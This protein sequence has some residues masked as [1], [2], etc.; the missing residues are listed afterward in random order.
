MAG[1]GRSPGLDA[2][3]FDEEG[4]THGLY[5]SARQAIVGGPV[6]GVLAGPPNNAARV[7]PSC[8]PRP[9][10]SNRRTARKSPL[11]HH[12]DIAEFLTSRRAKITPEQAGL[13]TYGQ[14][15]GAGGR[16]RGGG[17][18]GGGGGAVLKRPPGGG[19]GR[20]PPR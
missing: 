7:L 5:Q 9:V 14:R 20:R 19:G 2:V 3:G 11:E 6:K 8:L 16:P 10:R 17:P 1:S 15:R 12:A 18:P 13:P 4:C